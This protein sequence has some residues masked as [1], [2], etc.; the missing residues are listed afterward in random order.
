MI[1]LSLIEARKMGLRIA[2]ITPQKKSVL[3]ARRRAQ[4]TMPDEVLWRAVSAARPGAE[5]EYQGA[6]PG[7]RFRI[8]IALAD[9][10][11]AI[12][13]DGWQ[14][15]GK[16]KS[17]HQADRERQNLLAVQGWLIL[18]FT[19]GQIFKDMTGVLTTIDAACRQR[20]SPASSNTPSATVQRTQQVAISPSEL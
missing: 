6:V 17:A 3:P 5:R 16:F 15:H 19:A 12:E 1:R 18:R 14:Y 9:E 2:A 20:T 4:G 8:D 11:V 7:R 13:I 10:K